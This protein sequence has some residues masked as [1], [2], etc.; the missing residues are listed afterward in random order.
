VLVE[1]RAGIVEPWV[2]M[3]HEG[4]EVRSAILPEGESAHPPGLLDGVATLRAGPVGLDVD[5]RG[6]G[7]LG[8]VGAVVL[9]Q[10]GLQ[11]V[12]RMADELPVRLRR[13]ETQKSWDPRQRPEEACLSGGCSFRGQR[14]PQVDVR[15][16]DS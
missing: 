4:T 16:D 1:N 11:D 8:G 15:V 5:Q 9:R 7:H 14:V 3:H 2:D 6:D 12:V 13:H 10:V